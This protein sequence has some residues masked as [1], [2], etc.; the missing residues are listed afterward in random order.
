MKKRILVVDDDPTSLKTVESILT[1]SGYDVQTS[2]HA[3]DIEKITQ[4]YVPDLIIMDLLMPQVDGNEAVRRIQKNPSLNNIPIIFLTA[5]TMKDEERD[6]EF[7]INVNARSYR[8]LTKP[9]HAKSFLTE[10]QKLLT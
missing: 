5:V 1:T 3:E 9:V 8:T 10:I 4:S 7:E 6:L 2:T